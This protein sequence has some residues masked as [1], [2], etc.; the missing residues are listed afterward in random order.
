M[1][2]FTGMCVSI[3]KPLQVSGGGR[4]GGNWIVEERRMRRGEEGKIKGGGEVEMERGLKKWFQF[5]LR[6]RFNAFHSTYTGDTWA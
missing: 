2:E 5:S 6:L 4:R 1:C 3:C